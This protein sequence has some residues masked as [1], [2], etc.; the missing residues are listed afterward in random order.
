MGIFKEC[1]AI[2]VVC[3]L[4]REEVGGVGEIIFVFYEKSNFD[5]MSQ[6]HSLAEEPR[7]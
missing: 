5:L 4:G 3:L 7:E 6:G 2:S 1:H